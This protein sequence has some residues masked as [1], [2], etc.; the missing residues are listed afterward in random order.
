VAGPV[1]ITNKPFKIVQHDLR[2]YLPFWFLQ[3]DG[4]TPLD[5]TG[6]T[7][8]I[9]VA[10]VQKATDAPRVTAAKFRKECDILDALQG[11]GEYRWEGNDT[12]TA[13][14]FSYQFKILW[15]GTVEEPQTVPVDYY[16]DLIVLDDLT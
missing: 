6:A 11:H 4:E 14:P 1:I 7:V 13:G 3:A 8:E 10:T 9:V 15:P 5:I 2:P 16:L 12:D